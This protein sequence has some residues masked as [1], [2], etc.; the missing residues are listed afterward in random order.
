MYKNAS[1][2]KTTTNKPQ[3]NKIPKLQTPKKK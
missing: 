3:L 2:D 1:P